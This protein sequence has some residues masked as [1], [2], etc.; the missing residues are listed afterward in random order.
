MADADG[1]PA[2]WYSIPVACSAPLQW[3]QLNDSSLYQAFAPA[4]RQITDIRSIKVFLINVHGS[5]IF[6]IVG[7][8]DRPG[9]VGAANM[10]WIH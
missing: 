8:I 7:S 2:D 4:R 9:T 6:P 3:T 1:S 5:R 10:N